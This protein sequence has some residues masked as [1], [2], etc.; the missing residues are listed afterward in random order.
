MTQPVKE[1]QAFINYDENSINDSD[2]LISF[3]ISCD[4][5]LCKTAMRKLEAKYL[6]SHNLLGKWVKV[7][8]GVRLPDGEFDLVDYGSFLV[9][10]LTETK[11]NETTSIVAY[12]KMVN[13][14]TPYQK[15]DIKY[16]LCL[17]DYT[18]ILCNKC[19]LELGGNLLGNDV[20]IVKS[21]GVSTVDISQ[22]INTK[23]ISV[24]IS[25]NSYQANAPTVNA[26]REVKTLKGDVTLTVIGGNQ[27]Q[28]TNIGIQNI[29]LCAIGD[30]KDTIEITDGEIYLNKNVR[31][32]VLNGDENWDVG[33][34]GEGSYSLSV[35]NYRSV[36]H[37]VN[38]VSTHFLGI[39]YEDRTLVTGNLIYT[40]YVG[41]S[42]YVRNS[43]FSTLEEF[44]AFLRNQY[45]SGTPVI[46][47]YALNTPEHMEL[48]K[49][50]LP[51]LF[52]GTNR[53]S[54]SSD[55][56]PSNTT[57][58]YYQGNGAYNQMNDWQIT[59][60]K[61]TN[62]KY[63]D[64]WENIEG[65][66]YRDIFQQI[67][68]ATGTTCIIHD[69]KVY[70]KSLTNTGENLT[71]NNMFK[72][73]LEA[74]YGEINSVVL[75]RTPSEDNV[76]LQ[77]EASIQANGLTEFKIENNEIIDKDR[78][79]AITP[80][81]NALS[82]ITYYPF[83]ATT[84]GLGWYEIGD[85]IT[86]VNE[87]GDVFKTSLF[88]YSITVDGSVKE[89]LKTTAESKT[90]TQYQYA[91]TIA[92]Q[93][94]NTEFI[95]NKQEQY[96]KSLVRDMYEED[97]ILNEKYT[98]LE[99]DI[100]KFAF[101]IQNSGG[102]NLIKNSVMFAYNNEDNPYNWEVEGDGTLTRVSDVGFQNNGGLS[103]HGFML[104]NKTVRTEKIPVK[105]F[106]ENNPIYY[107]FSTKIKKGNYGTCYVK[108]YNPDV[109]EEHIIP[110][111]EDETSELNEYSK[112]GLK[113]LGEYY[114]IE[115]YGSADSN[116]IFT[117][118]MFAIGENKSQWTQANGEVMNTQVNISLD[119]IV[120][121]SDTVLGDY[122]V[123]S[124]YEFSGWSNVNGTMTKVFTLNRGVTEVKKLLASDEIAM[125][126]LKIIPITTGDMQGWA[127]VIA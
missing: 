46:V 39:S 44:K 51:N 83:E 18:K 82:G 24:I 114:I 96:I 123:I 8:F 62:G 99:Q 93:L 108:I 113:P 59:A 60:T 70:F 73:K 81:F 64:L 86:I 50:D 100:E 42:L 2:D 87:T 52:N 102:A 111:T 54:V 84:E 90:Q 25:G 63:I 53:I 31:K 3:K 27:E 10:E 19:G 79:N 104:A 37:T 7:G 17:V 67:A 21:S 85:N 11:D 15:L 66:T 77:N 117:D 4:S 5:G 48:G 72:L 107:S 121:R 26:P 45:E 34:Y 61:D 47:Y 109:D 95:V 105:P 103:C 13:A 112:I 97:G 92:K 32:I 58:A 6:G 91:T 119:G 36:G 98:S 122:T 55:L 1:I 57:V 40:D 88:N 35:D 101:N 94:K 56:A 29:E 20:E 68:Q 22:A 38:V 80:I 75:S 120:V 65:I 124:K 110:L 30:I 49:C 33:Y 118:N 127:F 23:P 69:D 74:P 115:F 16:P 14:M 76:Y 28:K 106:D 125:P 89:T 78:E 116:V 71:Y 9:T 126:P 12:D 43:G 41:N